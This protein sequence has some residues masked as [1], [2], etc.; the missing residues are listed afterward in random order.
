MP[1]QP[2]NNC[3]RPATAADLGGSGT[4]GARFSDQ[5]YP[6]KYLC[7]AAPLGSGYQPGGGDGAMLRTYLSVNGAPAA[8]TPDQNRT[9]G[10]SIHR[11]GAELPVAVRQFGPATPVFLGERESPGQTAGAGSGALSW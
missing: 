2:K 1:N 11:P 10:R 8:R 9:V 4:A 6:S 7:P 3:N 5:R